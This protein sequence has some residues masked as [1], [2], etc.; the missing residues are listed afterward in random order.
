MT[1]A[2]SKLDVC[3]RCCNG[4]STRASARPAQPVE[5]ATR[6]SMRLHPH[7]SLEPKT[8]RR[9]RRSTRPAVLPYPRKRRGRRARAAAPASARCGVVRGPG[10]PS[11]SQRPATAEARAC[12]PREDALRSDGSCAGRARAR[13]RRR[14]GRRWRG[15]HTPCVRW[16]AGA[17][18]DVRHEQSTDRAILALRVGGT[19]RVG[20]HFSPYRPVPRRN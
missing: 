3:F 7:P 8:T 18:G 14:R 9:R 6:P 20:I 10:A 12:D 1:L 19:F 15:L 11:T 2:I 17:A 5:Q 16:K 13:G 4:R